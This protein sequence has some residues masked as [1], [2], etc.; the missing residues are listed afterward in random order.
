MAEVLSATLARYD[1]LSY[2]V[3]SMV[4]F[5]AVGMAYKAWKDNRR[6][7]GSFEI[8]PVQFLMAQVERVERN[9]NSRIES[10]HRRIDQIENRVVNME[11]R[12]GR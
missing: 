6:S 9:V 8:D 10:T 1:V 12:R 2:L 5:A 4:V 7:P 11:H 3:A